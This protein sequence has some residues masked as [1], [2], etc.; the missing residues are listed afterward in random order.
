[1]HC[2]FSPKLS[3]IAA[4]CVPSLPLDFPW[5]K[6]VFVF[7]CSVQ[8][9]CLLM[10]QSC[11]GWLDSLR[12]SKDKTSSVQCANSRLLL[13]HNSQCPHAFQRKRQV[14]FSVRKCCLLTAHSVHILFKGK[15]GFPSVCGN[16]ACSQLTVSTFFSKEKTGSLQCVE[17]LLAHCCSIRQLV[18]QVPFS[19]PLLVVSL[20][21][22]NP[23]IT[24]LTA[25]DV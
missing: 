19:F 14:P 20:S 24:T 15:D 16:S 7:L 25:H 6:H 1:M 18:N 21:V 2:I 12:H 9:G 8:F 17:I 5:I 10:P 11:T 3:P 22:N 4:M 13:A 23:Y